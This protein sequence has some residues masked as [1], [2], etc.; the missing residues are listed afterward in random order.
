MLSVRNVYWPAFSAQ[1]ARL[2][3]KRASPASHRL[4]NMLHWEGP[5]RIHRICTA[6]SRL[7]PTTPWAI[8]DYCTCVRK[9]VRKHSILSP[10]SSVIYGVRLFAHAISSWAPASF[11]YVGAAA[12][13]GPI[14]NCLRRG[15]LAISFFFFKYISK[16]NS[17]K[18]DGENKIEEAIHY[19]MKHSAI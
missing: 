1:L 12:I 6:I 8:R 11:N 10:L 14:N 17:K 4:V 13:V 19:H 5:W 18:K 2:M 9:C 15:T 16:D 7:S 3:N